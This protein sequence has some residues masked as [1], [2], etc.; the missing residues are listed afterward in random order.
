[1]RF[2]LALCAAVLLAL[3]ASLWFLIGGD[4][5]QVLAAPDERAAAAARDGAQA[6]VLTGAGAAGATHESAARSS[7][8][9]ASATAAA[10]S[11]PA[12]EP[13][14][15]AG[16]IVDAQGQPVPGA[17]VRALGT[18]EEG[19]VLPL[20][21]EPEALPRAYW[22][23]KQTVS[24]EQGRYRI[25]ALDKGALRLAVRAAGF[26][27]RYENRWRVLG[28]PGQQLPDLVL[29]P[30]SQ[31]AGRVV[32]RAGQGLAGVTLLES[33]D[34]AQSSLGV[35]F[36]GRGIPLAQTAA[37]GSFAIDA[38]AAGPWRL[39]VD[40]PGHQ[41]RVEEG[42]TR[43]GGE[44]V[45]GLTFVLDAGLEIRG[46]LVSEAA[47]PTPLRVVARPV[48]PRAERTRDGAEAEPAPLTV[49]GQRGRQADVAA[50]GSFAVAGLVPGAD[51]RLG[52]SQQSAETGLWKRATAVEGTTA[53]AGQHGVELA[54]KPECALV[55]RVVDARTKA[56]L[57]AL[58]VWAGVGRE[59]ALRDDQNEP[60]TH[61]PAGEVRCGELRP[62]AGKPI[63]LRVRAA[64]HRDHERK[65][66]L[67][68]AGETKDLGE[69]ALE[70]LAQLG[71]RVLDAATQQPLAGARV[72]LST[73][74]ADHARNW[75]S[76]EP[77]RGER[78]DTGLWSAVT[79]ASGL[80]QVDAPAGKLVAVGASAQGYLAS[81]PELRT[82]APEAPFETIELALRRGGVLLVRVQDPGGR[83]VAG[84]GIAHLNPGEAEDNEGW[85]SITAEKKTDDKGEARF[86]RL[87]PGVHRFVL[88]DAAADTWIDPD[89]THTARPVWVER[90]VA[91]G[92]HDELVFVAPPRGSILGRVREGGRALDGAQ[93]KLARLREDGGV[94]SGGWGGSD[95]PYATLSDH[96]GEWRFEGLRCGEYVL[97]VHH[98][99]R[100]MSARFR[101]SVRE[102]PQRYEFELDVASIEGTV[103]DIQGR[104]LAGLEVSV[105]SPEGEEFDDV[106]YQ[107]VMREDDRGNTQS[108]Y[109]PG[110]RSS[111]RTDAR[112]H[113]ALRGLATNR[114]LIVQI[115]SDLVEAASSPPITLSPDEVRT[116]VDFRLRRAGRI[117]VS[118]SSPPAQRDQ[119]YE[120]RIFKLAEGQETLAQSTWIGSW[121]QNQT[122]RGLAPGR[123][124]V[125]LL[126]PGGGEAPAGEGQAPPAQ[127]LEVEAEKTAQVSFAPY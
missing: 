102:S 100:R 46:R 51:Y 73:R 97:A 56:P 105:Y 41:L 11:A 80:A 63:H 98:A 39:I 127:E 114:Q 66:I 44:R 76:S 32:D 26:A 68:A 94:D 86:E 42:R 95:D 116:G 87:R 55:F 104:P 27:P 22:K 31:L 61:F 47:L 89:D 119:W 79:D 96:E 29:L 92:S 57:E 70:P 33:L 9:D 72:L 118:F 82:L 117:E 23:Q 10:S 67:L 58:V 48:P 38:L 59:R 110:T 36:P 1:M 84:V 37:D 91:E 64:G 107:L 35:T 81:E 69:I 122:V 52:V 30:G 2:A 5:T 124:K 88:H 60:R 40:G 4:D 3:L 126:R 106:P 15:I 50:D 93:L 62:Q 101:V 115:Q 8:V 103:L 65:D 111:E 113:Y 6:G 123:Y 13:P 125:V 17:R 24:D 14:A 43:A 74:D 7:V 83:P 20:D 77:G 71:V 109:Q 121:N 45:A 19:F 21:L 108:D 53:R 112:G 28:E 49:E 85:S 18:N 16:R 25:E 120:V 34:R 75:L 90:N 78:T 12:A 54:W 99:S